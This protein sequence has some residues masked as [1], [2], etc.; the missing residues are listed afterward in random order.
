MGLTILLA[1][2]G[3]L[4]IQQSGSNSSDGAQLVFMGIYMIVF[5]ATLFI[6]E[7]LQI[8]PIPYLNMAFMKNFGF[9]YGPIGRGMYTLL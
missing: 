7:L 4:G 9:L 1:A 8:C 5:A 6:Y 2:T 3:A